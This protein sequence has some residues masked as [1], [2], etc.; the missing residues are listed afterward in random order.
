MVHN[1]DAED[2]LLGKEDPASPDAVG[3]AEKLSD[4]ALEPQA[5]SRLKLEQSGLPNQFG[6]M[7]LVNSA[8]DR[9][10]AYNS[11]AETG[12]PIT[13]G[14]SRAAE[15]TDTTAKVTDLFYT[16]LGVG[17]DK[18]ARNEDTGVPKKQADGSLI[19]RF[20]DGISRTEWQDGTVKTQYKDGHFVLHKPEAGG[21]YREEHGGNLRAEDNF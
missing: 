9:R 2:T 14:L 13:A 6:D 18:T 19:T 8:G 1:K 21:G 5:P 4:E 3:A 11:P 7:E 12:E 17:N 16:I 10:L 20:R 15:I